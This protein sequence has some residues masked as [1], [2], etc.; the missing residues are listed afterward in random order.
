MT[1]SDDVYPVFVNFG[2]WP[3]HA[4]VVVDEIEARANARICHLRKCD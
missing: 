1:E 2:D 4:P 3:I